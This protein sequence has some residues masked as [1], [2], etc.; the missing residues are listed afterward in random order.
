[1]V[2]TWRR[3]GDW[4]RHGHGSGI[5]SWRQRGCLYDRLHGVRPPNP[6]TYWYCGTWSWGL[7]IERLLYDAGAAK[8][9]PMQYDLTPL[10]MAS[11]SGHMEV[12]RLL[13]DAGAT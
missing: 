11:P 12:V 2:T 10:Q 4:R 9:R 7:H 5:G 3:H 8:G 13:C 6:F 1:M